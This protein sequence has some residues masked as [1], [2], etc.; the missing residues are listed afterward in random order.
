YAADLNAMPVK[1]VP[2]ASSGICSSIVDFFTTACQ[3]AA[4]G[5]RFYG[6]VDMGATYET[7]GAPMNK[8]LGVNSFLGKMSN[9][10]QFLT[11]PGASTVGFQIKEPLGSGWSFVGQ[12][13][14]GFNPYSLQLLNG[15]H[16]VFNAIGTPLS[17][18]TSFGDSNSQGA[19]Y[20]NLGFTG[21]SHDTWGTLT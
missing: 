19:F 15:V 3:V 20:N 10:A 6:T 21:V 12:V 11:V 17:Q 5:V 18:Q 1:A 14:A 13:E 4:Y 16:S 8:I 7:N 2:I 9:G